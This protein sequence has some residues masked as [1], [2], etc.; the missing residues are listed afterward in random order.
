MSQLLRP[1]R[2]RAFQ[3]LAL[4][5]AIAGFSLASVFLLQAE[6]EKRFA[7]RTAEMLGGELVLTG[8]QAPEDAQQALLATTG[9]TLKTSA[10]VDFSTVLVHQGELLLVSARAVDAN[11]P[12]YGAIQLAQTR[13]GPSVE[14]ANGPPPGELWVADQVLDRL[15]LKLGDIIKVG[16]RALRVSAIIRQLPDQSAG[17][18]S[19]NPRVVFNARELEATGVIGPG[20]RLRY[21]Q[22]IAG[23]PEQVE[24][25][26]AALKSGLRA[27]QRLE[28]V[29]HAAVR[30]MGP[31]R[32]LTLWANLA[33]LLISVLC[34]ATVY[35]ATSQRVEQRARL[36]GLLRS[37]GAPRRQILQ[38]ILGGEFVAVLPPALIG[39]VLGVA[40][41]AL[42][43]HLLDWQGP[44][45]ATG[46]RWLIILFA[47]LVLWLAFA[48]PRLSALVRI[49]AIEILNRRNASRLLSTHVELSAALAAPVLLAGLLTRSLAE[50]GSLLGLLVALGVGLPALLWPMLKALDLASTRLPLAARLAIRRLSR[51]PTLTLPLLA[52]LTLAMAIIALA[53][54]TG[55]RLLDDWRTR[56]PEKAP[57]YFVL[58]LFER[59]LSTFNGWLAR[60]DA[61]A[62]PLYP[63]VRGRLSEINGEPITAAVTKER[64]DN[65]ESMNRDL[66]LTEAA[67]ML[68]SNKIIAGRWHPAPGTVSVEQELAERLGLDIGDHLVFTTSQGLLSAEIASIR[69]VDWDT[70]EPN[71]YFMFHPGGL[72]NQDITWLTGFWL[73]DGAGKRLAELMESLPHITLLDVNTLLDKANEIIAQASGATA[74]LAVLL[75]SAAVLVL[76]AALLG[77]QAQ[78]GRDNALLRTLG[79]NRSLL[80]RVVWLEF[81]CL[82]ASAAL[83]AIVIA[84]ISLYPLTS[85]LLN[86][87]PDLS[88]WQGIPMAIGLAVAILGVLAS[89]GALEKPALSLLRDGG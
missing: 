59:D 31:L 77:G 28:D 38:R 73:A 40:F 19:M 36:A 52:A 78:R 16:N 86:D 67:D 81:L 48:L 37:F 23:T 10:V 76:I 87:L 15:A 51:R 29:E 45:A 17:F 1:W 22:L 85:R 2:E 69:A 42:L 11:Y 66:A 84:L 9:N 8:T 3:I 14:R 41:I 83:A 33:V 47:P 35:L 54:Q 50:L 20:T 62:Q 75:V 68:A 88:W 6:L 79:G 12:L 49:P 57:N 74:L 26:S 32:Q 5:L 64:E 21:R 63:I 27:D 30:S 24:H 55:T 34:G 61:V 65:H 89:R 60:H 46:G 72:S 25:L 18:Y 39:C 44:L 7:V 4:A 13:F 53:G 56:L 58:N 80:Y 82:C 43:H 70:F 71:F